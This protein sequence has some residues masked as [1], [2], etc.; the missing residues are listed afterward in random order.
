MLENQHDEINPSKLPRTTVY[1]RAQPLKVSDIDSRVT[2][3]TRPFAHGG[4]LLGHGFRLVDIAP[5]DA[6]V[7]TEV[8]QCAYLDAAQVPV[9]AGAEDDFVVWQNSTK[10]SMFPSDY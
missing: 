2:Q 4:E 8:D 10:V 9:S 6:R 3:H 7:S 5:H 1:S